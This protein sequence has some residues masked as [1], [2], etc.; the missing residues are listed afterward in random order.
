MLRKYS[1]LFGI[2]IGLL[3]LFIATLYYP[4]GSQ[5]DR[6]AAGY[7]WK[8]NYLSNL[9]GPKAMNGA[10]NASRPWAVAGMFFLCAGIVVFFIEFPKKIPSKGAARVV[11]W[12]GAGGMLCAFLAVTPYHDIMITI[13]STLVLV[14]MFYITVFVFRSKLH[15]FKILCVIGLIVPYCCNYVYYTGH[16]LAFLPIMQKVCIA[17]T[18]TWVLALQYFTTTNDF[19]SKKAV[20]TK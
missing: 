19:A 18:I 20:A 15:L 8:N 1:I 11:T 7:D 3:L 16:Y 14:S 17:T 13:A 5:Y 2:I 10:D 6:N 4:G 12:F 9:F